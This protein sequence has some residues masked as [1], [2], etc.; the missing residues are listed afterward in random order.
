VDLFKNNNF[1]E[2]SLL[3]ALSF[4]KD[5]IFSEE[6]ASKKGFLQGL[7]PRIKAIS[8]LLFII[9]GVLTKNINVILGLYAYSLLL[10]Y[11]SQI[12]LLSFLKRTWI[13]IPLF[14]LFI[15]I[16]AVFSIVT[17]GQ[18]MAEF[19]FRGIK[20][21][22]TRQGLL[23]ASLFVS[24]V[25]NSVS[26]AI[27]LSMTT[28]HYELLKALRAFGVPQIFVMTIG[29]CYR[30]IYLF[31]EIIQNTYLAIKSRAGKIVSYDRGQRMVAWNIASLWHRS[32]HLNQEVYLAMLSRGYQG[33]AVLLDD[34]QIK[35]KDIWWLCTSGIIF[36][37]INYIT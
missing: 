29:M 6:Y 8:F 1:I 9:Q 13:F 27:L 22:I 7:D 4:I 5:S 35:A 10:A 2:R 15:A 21:I 25:V 31:V 17:P 23:G 18:S 32:Y 16:P 19:S 30:Y 20:L 28:K 33:E 11:I 26:F 12:D 24:R 34:F 3:G 14:S 37:Y 36:L